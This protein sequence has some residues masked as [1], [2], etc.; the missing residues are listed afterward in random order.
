[1]EES[2][3]MT[4]IKICGLTSPKEADYV[5]EAHADF[6][7]FVLFYPKSKRNLTISQAK[8][9]FT[10]LD[11]EINKVAVVVSPTLE[12]IIQIEN[13]GFDYLQIHGTLTNEL[14]SAIHLPILKA[15][16]V[17]D[18][19]QYDTFHQEDKIK[20]YVFDAAVPGSGKTFNW[21]LVKKIP[22]DEKLFI[23]AGGLNEDNVAEAINAIKPDAVDVSSG[24]E[25]ADGTPG[26][27]PQR[28]RDFVQAIKTTI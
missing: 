8:E 24:V 23:L 6:A 26:K 4:K 5:N 11:K 3:L 21:N 17:K 22:R 10:A 2:S 12:E 16:N 28:I 25:F 18:M 13:A 20:G 14:L 1:M 9:I 15:F 7:G 19:E 27:D